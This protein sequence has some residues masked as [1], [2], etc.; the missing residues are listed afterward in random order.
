MPLLD[1]SCVP[2]GRNNDSGN[3]WQR[4]WCEVPAN[5]LP[6][7]NKACFLLGKSPQNLPG[8]DAGD[9]SPCLPCKQETTVPRA[10][11]LIERWQET[12]SLSSRF[13]LLCQG[14][15]EQE[16]SALGTWQ[17]PSQLS[18]SPGAGIPVV[19]A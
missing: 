10:T 3:M 4:G 18:I 16:R 11:E 12:L 13:K 8:N 1:M 17:R 6:Y 2:A 5:P 14:Q 9:A 7:G 19:L 15:K